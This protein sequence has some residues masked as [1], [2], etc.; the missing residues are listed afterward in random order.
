MFFFIQNDGALRSSARPGGMELGTQDCLYQYVAICNT[1]FG[2]PFHYAG[3]KNLVTDGK[4][5]VTE[6]LCK[7]VAVTSKE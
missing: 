5:S 4:S 6:N 3:S 1:L 2:T 7:F